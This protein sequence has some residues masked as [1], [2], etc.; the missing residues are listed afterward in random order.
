MSDHMRSGVITLLTDFG[1]DDAYVGIMKGV[2]LRID[3]TARLVDLT[4]A[5]PP[6]RIVVGALILRSAVGYFPDGTVHLAVVDPGVGSARRPIMI[7]TGRGLLVGPDNGILY[8]AAAALGGG[9]ARLL[10]DERFFVHPISPTFHGRDIF[11]PVAAHLA[12]GTDPAEIGPP[13]DSIVELSL[14]APGCMGSILTGEVVHV[15]HFGNLIT[16]IT[17]D[18]LSRFPVQQL[19]VSIN[20]TPIGTLLTTYSGVSEG[21]PIALIGSW[22][23]LELAIRNGNAAEKFAAGPG[24]PVTVV[25]E[26]RDA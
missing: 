26:S 9:T 18:L 22:G 6:Q 24:T 13:L 23:L 3:P 12:R 5:V 8:P 20:E 17:A 4:H 1:L 15:D 25:L 11:A 16:N 14:P 7:E 19:S 2:M 10:A 21:A